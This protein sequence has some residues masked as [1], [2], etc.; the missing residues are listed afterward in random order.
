MI[1][2]GVEFWFCLNE[3]GKLKLFFLVLN[4]WVEEFDGK[5][6]VK[7]FFFFGFLNKF[8][9]ED[10]YYNIM[11]FML[12][13]LYNLLIYSILYIINRGILNYLFIKKIFNYIFFMCKVLFLV[14]WKVKKFKFKL[15]L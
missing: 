3:N 6:N 10:K 8:F 13:N 7:L 12:Y 9:E 11:L 4:V 1:E 2:E 14:L 15:Y 5:E